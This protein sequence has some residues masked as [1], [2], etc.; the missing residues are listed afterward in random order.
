VLGQFG[1]IHLRQPQVMPDAKAVFGSLDQARLL[2]LSGSPA[3]VLANWLVLG[4]PLIDSLQGRVTPRPV[5]KAQL[6][7]PIDRQHSRHELLGAMMSSADDGS[8]YACP[9]S[10]TGSNALRTAIDCNA[11]IALPEGRQHFAAG[12]IVEILPFQ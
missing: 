7:A 2:G 8:L 4:R 3:S 11:L 10:L 5:L 12:S 9:Q 6:V 1:Q